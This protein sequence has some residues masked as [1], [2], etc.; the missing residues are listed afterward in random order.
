MENILVVDDEKNIVTII[1]KMLEKWGYNAVQ[2]TSG[3][4][5]LEKIKSAPIDLVITD[6]MM[7]KMDGITLIGK[8]LEHYENMVIIVL[9][10]YPT[11]DSAVQAIKAGAYDFMAKPI[12]ADELKFKIDR[13]IERKNLIKS[14]SFLKGLNWALI[15]SIPFWLILG[16]ILAS[17][18]S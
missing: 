16:I 6:L 3:D 12:Q 15:F 7:P 10:G 8:I 18:L 2:A 13:S 1:S 14:R 4:E 11:I 5:A 17:I 9:T